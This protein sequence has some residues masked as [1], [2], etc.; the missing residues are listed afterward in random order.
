MAVVTDPGGGRHRHVAARPAQGLRRLRRAR[1]AGWFELHTRDYDA[2]VEFYR[3][4]FS[5]DTHA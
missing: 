1:H 4:V 5:W 3:D 2:S